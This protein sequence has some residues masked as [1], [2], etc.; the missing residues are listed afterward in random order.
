MIAGTTRPGEFLLRGR[1]LFMTTIAENSGLVTAIN[2]FTV[3]P[4]NQQKLLD[5]LAHATDTSVRD[6]PGFVSA[7]LHRSVDGT[8]VAMYAQWRS[9]EHYQRYQSMRSNPG[10]STYVAEILAIAR[11]DPGMY[12]VVQVFS[13]PSGPDA[14]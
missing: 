10:A 11:F 7:A 4:L 12:E 13:G 8:K 6:V 5:L 9:A 2:V 3:D 14:E 1:R